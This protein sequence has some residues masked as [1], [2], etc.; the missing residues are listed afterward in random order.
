MAFDILVALVSIGTFGSFS[1]AVA[2]HFSSAQMPGGMRLISI[3]ALMSTIL[4]LVLTFWVDQ[5]LVAQLLG[6]IIEL[7][8]CSLFWWAI[9]TSRNAQLKLAFDPAVPSSVLAVGPYRLIRHPLYSSYC[10]FWIGWAIA[11]WSPLAM[12][13]AVVLVAIYVIAARGEEASF[14]SSPLAREYEVYR[15][16]TGFFL[17]FV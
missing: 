9:A 4:L 7:C 14:A 1:W 8:A 11:T 5:P 6:V 17:P 3:V 10:I 2:R 12:I 15:A 16:R 13:P